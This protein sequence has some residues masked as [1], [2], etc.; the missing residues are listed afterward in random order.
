MHSLLLVT[1]KRI[2]TVCVKC[3]VEPVHSSNARIVLGTKC[4]QPLWAQ[5]RNMTPSGSW[6]GCLD[7]IQPDN[8]G[9]RHSARSCGQAR[10]QAAVSCP[11]LES[12]LDTLWTLSLSYQLS[13]FRR[14]F[15]LATRIVLLQH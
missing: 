7:E 5:T 8:Q 2:Y 10:T 1:L 9:C 14:L 11:L 4:L 15:K 6:Q 3:F 12:P 13:F